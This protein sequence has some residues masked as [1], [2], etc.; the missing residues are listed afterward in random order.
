MHK[1]MERIRVNLEKSYRDTYEILIGEDI[2]NEVG[3]I[4]KVKDQADRYVILTDSN[5]NPL[6]GEQVRERFRETTRPVDLI[7]IPAGESSKSLETVLDVAR[8]LVGFKAS[9]KSLLI[10]LGG[11]VVGDVTGFVASIYMRSV[12]YIQIPTTLLAQVDSSVGGKTGVDLPEGK[13]LLGTFYQP[14]AVYVD[15]SFLRTLSDQDFGNG[16]AEII[17][18]SIIAD[19]GLFELL[20]H[21][22]NGIKKRDPSLMKSLVGRSCK[23]KAGIIEMDEKELGLR[24][25]LNFGHTLG[26]ALEAASDYGLSHGQAVAIGMAGAALISHRLNHLNKASYARIVRLI[27]GYGL[28]TKI[29]ADMDSAQIP[30]FMATDK[31]AVGGELHFVLTKGIGAP[32]VTPEVPASVVVEAIE[33]LKR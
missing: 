6:Y 31:K 23:I 10:A 11:G 27:E 28:P 19:N 4:T 15:L 29:P 8:K 3:L 26:H 2:I 32:F 17:K 22:S 33:E 20:E 5:V 12:P 21:E 14:K 1:D 16:M 9:R 25:I 18:Y 24:R 30:T 13:N 7:E